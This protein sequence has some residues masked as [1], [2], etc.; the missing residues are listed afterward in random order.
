MNKRLMLF[1][2]SFAIFILAVTTIK[3]ITAF[4]GDFVVNHNVSTF[5]SKSNVN[6]NIKV[7]IGTLK[8][9][10]EIENFNIKTAGK[11]SIPY[12]FTVETGTVTLQVIKSN[13]VMWEKVISPST[14]GL[15][16]LEGVKGKYSISL[17]TEEAKKIN[18]KLS[19]K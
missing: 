19:L 10:Y 12:E 6:G 11:I 1:I 2:I 5:T 15:I 14:T 13:M 18:M 9:T 8:G 4:G 7:S 17:L 3:L 16:E